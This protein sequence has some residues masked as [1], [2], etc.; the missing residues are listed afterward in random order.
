MKVRSSL[1][2]ASYSARSKAYAQAMVENGLEPEKILLYGDRRKDAPQKT[3]GPCGADESTGLFFPD[4]SI[5]L[6]R[7]VLEAGWEHQETG[8][9]N[10]NAP[11]IEEAIR[12]MNP[13]IVIY[14]GYGGQIVGE[15]ALNAAPFLHAHS[16][17]LPDERGSTTIYYSILARRKC[18][19]SVLTLSPVIDE[20]PILLRKE[21]PRPKP[22]WDIDYLYDNA[23]R[24]DLLVDVLRVY[25]DDGAFPP[26]ISQ[27]RHEGSAYYVIHP[28]LKHIS[29]LSLE[30]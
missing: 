1:F 18:G 2:L 30:S 12:Q 21:Y 4:L 9:E 24:A 8:C 10:I 20:G 6:K 19:V 22:G 15:R 25:Q 7:T 27:D 14:A 23:I 13:K 3:S 29:M 28:V 17:W 26:P 11:D 5:P 16:G